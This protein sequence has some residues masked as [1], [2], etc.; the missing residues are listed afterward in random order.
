MHVDRPADALP[1]TLV[2]HLG[3]GKLAVAQKVLAVMGKGRE[4]FLQLRFQRNQS[5]TG[6]AL[7]WTDVPPIPYKAYR[8][9]DVNQISLKVDI[10]PLQ[11]Q[12]FAA[13]DT[14][15][16][17]QRYQQPILEFQ[18]GQMGDDILCIFNG[19][20]FTYGLFLAVG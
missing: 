8:S 16:D 9:A 6:L 12:R 20:G 14:G 18:P 3:N 17:Q 5:H 11:P 19:E 13:S 15:K 1:A 2:G 10:L 4:D 7:G